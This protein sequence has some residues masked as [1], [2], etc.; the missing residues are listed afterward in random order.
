MKFQFYYE[1]LI[2]SEEYQSFLKECPT[3]FPCSALFI[4]DKEKNENKVHFDY[5]IPGQEKIFSFD[6]SNGVDRIP[7]DNIDQIV[8]EKLGMNYTFDLANYEKEIEKEIK[9]QEIKGTLQKL[10][11][12]L[13]T[14][15]KKPYLI[16][17]GFMSNLGLLKVSIN[18]ET[19]K[20]ESFEKKSFFDLIRVVKGKKKKD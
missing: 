18:L 14:K 11:F 12:S 19:S 6:L 10:L 16:I 20:I 9:K 1:K 17:T 3:A 13:Q 2:N 7:I 15:D 5:F 8:P 4:I